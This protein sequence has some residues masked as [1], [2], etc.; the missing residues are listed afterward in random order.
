MTAASTSQVTLGWSP[1]KGGGSV[2]SEDKTQGMHGFD[3]RG[4]ARIQR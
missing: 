3:I 2:G 4:S 1:A